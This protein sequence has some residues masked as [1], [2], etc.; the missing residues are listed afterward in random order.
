MLTCEARWL[1]DQPLKFRQDHL[2]KPAVQ[3]RVQALKAELL[4]QHAVRQAAEK[5]QKDKASSPTSCATTIGS[6]TRSP[7]ESLRLI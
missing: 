6:L 7:Q 5:A 3:G 4:R 1:L 2:Q